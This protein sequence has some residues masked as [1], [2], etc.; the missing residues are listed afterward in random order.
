MAESDLHRDRMFY[1]IETLKGRFANRPD[2]YVSGNNFLYYAQGKP[3]K[4]VS[5][6]CYV[7][8]G[9]ANRPRPLYKTWEEGGHLPDVVIELTSKTTRVQ[10]TRH[11]FRLYEQV[12][13]I[14]EY[15]LFD[16]LGDYLNLRLQGYRLEQGVYVPIPLIEDRLQSIRLGLDLVLSGDIMRFYDP[17]QEEWVHSPW[18]QA[19]RAEHLLQEETLARAIAERLLQEES[20]ARATAE[21]SLLDANEEI[22]RLR[23]EL[24]KNR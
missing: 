5:P 24:E 3:R 12:L 16:P 9:V 23:A 2:V 10:D 14:P 8:F 21:R 15:F 20:L 13:R 11:K 6:D 4:C 18:E 1:N 22:A 7:V 17:V 19:E